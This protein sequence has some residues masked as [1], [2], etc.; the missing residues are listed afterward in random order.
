MSIPPITD[1]QAR[2][3]SNPEPTIDPAEPDRPESGVQ[4]APG[5][6]TGKTLP[7]ELRKALARVTDVASLPEVTTKIVEVV[8]DPRTTIHRV[9]EVVQADPALAARILRIVNSAFYGLPAQVASLERAILMLGL[10]AVRN[11]ALAASVSRLLKRDQITD[12]FTTLDLWEHS[13][14]VAVCSRLLAKAAKSPVPDET[15]AAGLLHDLG[16]IVSQQ[17]FRNKMQTVAESCLAQPE[18]FC[19][20]EERVIGAD[21]QAFGWTLATKWKFPPALRYAI[22]YHHAPSSLQ[23][24]FQKIA[25]TVYLADVVCCRQRHGFW[26]TAQHEELAEWMMKLI[27][28]GFADVE[29]IQAELPTQLAEALSVLAPD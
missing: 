6:S 4:Q 28:V 9:G 14:A 20:V 17:M 12:Q 2:K 7:P 15:F 26:L 10:S 5:L 24:E 8:E 3:S 29:G 19:A 16:L 27:G 18:S 13:V 25:A 22:G 11:L 21:H 1:R 23:P